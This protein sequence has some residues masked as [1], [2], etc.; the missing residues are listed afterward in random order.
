[1]ELKC[2]QKVRF[3]KEFKD[4]KKN[5]LISFAPDNIFH[6]RRRNYV[7]R[8]LFRV[9]IVLQGYLYY[10]LS[11]IFHYLSH[12]GNQHLFYFYLMLRK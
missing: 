8:R 1:M 5:N 9:F 3:I 7:L 2:L 10:F 6:R 12:Y 4:D 11:A